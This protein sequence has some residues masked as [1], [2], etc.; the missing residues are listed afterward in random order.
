MLFTA[1]RTPL[2]RLRAFDRELTVR[3]ADAIVHRHFEEA[4]RI[5][6]R[7][8]AARRAIL[9]AEELG[10]DRVAVPSV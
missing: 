7:R 2:G 1:A 8:R 6:D 3:Y 5:Y 9:T 10:G 4:A